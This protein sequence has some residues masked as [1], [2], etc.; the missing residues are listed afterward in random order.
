MIKPV[1][2]AGFVVCKNILYEYLGASIGGL[3]RYGFNGKENDNEVKGEGNQINYGMRIYD[4]RIGRFLSVDPLQKQYP[5]LTPYQFT[6][7]NPIENVDLDGKEIYDYR[8]DLDDKGHKIGFVFL[9][10]NVGAPLGWTIFDLF[11]M[12]IPSLDVYQSGKFVGTYSFNTA[13]QGGL[14]VL[15]KVAYDED[16]RNEFMN[17]VQTDGQK[18]TQHAEEIGNTVAEGFQTAATVNYAMSRSQAAPQRTTNA[19]TVTK[20]TNQ[21]TT[22]VQGGN[23]NAAKVNTESNSFT[24]VGRWMQAKEYEAMKS[25]GRI[26]EGAGGMTFTATSGPASFRK[27]A[28][29]DSVYVEFDVPTNSLLQGGQADWFKTIGGGANAAMKYQLKKQGG[30]LNPEVKNISEVKEKKD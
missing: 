18:Q 11:G 24:R 25:T 27:Q 1:N 7:N 15:R 23:T 22:A 2:L 21:Q 28:G 3:Y 12:K 30:M 29:P 8:L 13:S 4:P 19:T 26:Q 9:G 14:N 6:A 5:E 10:K 20:Q 17:T 16:Y